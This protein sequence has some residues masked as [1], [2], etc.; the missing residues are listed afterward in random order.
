L[1]QLAKEAE[2]AST[3]KEARELTPHQILRVNDS[4][5]GAMALMLSDFTG[6]VSDFAQSYRKFHAFPIAQKIYQH[7][8]TRS[9]KVLEP[10][11]EYTLVDEIAD[12][13][14]IHDWYQWIADPGVATDPV[15]N[16]AVATGDPPQGTTNPELLRS[17]DMASTMFLLAALERFEKLPA[18]KI[19]QLALEIAVLGMSGLDYASPEKKYRLSAIPDE[20]FSGLELMCLMHVGLRH[21]DPYIETG[22]DLDEPLATARK[23]YAARGG[24]AG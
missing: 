24:K 3:N 9:K 14:G 21:A 5:N 19:K 13:I 7:F 23:L 4:L 18:T 20:E 17:K 6:G 2:S 8:Q 22:M 12:M 11:D 10:S 1:I 16:Q 15:R